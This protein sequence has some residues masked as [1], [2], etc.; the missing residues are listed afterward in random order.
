MKKN[1][2]QETKS[3][4]INNSHSIEPKVGTSNLRF[5]LTEITKEDWKSPENYSYFLCVLRVLCAFVRWIFSYLLYLR[6]S[7]KRIFYHRVSLRMALLATILLAGFFVGCNRNNTSERSTAALSGAKPGLGIKY[8]RNFS[9]NYLGN[10]VKLVTDS[11]RNKLLLVP[12]GVTAPSGYNDVVLIETPIERALFTSTTYVGFLGAL[13]TDSV[14]NS[15]AAVCTPEEEWPTP[16]ILARFRNG[17]TRYINHGL[18]A[19]GDIEEII[20][21]GAGFAFTAG[22]D[23]SDMRLRNLLDEV[24]IK[25]ATLLE[26]MEDGNLAYLEWIKFFAAFFNLDEEADRIFEGKL[27]RL[28]EL[29]EK[30]SLVSNIPTVAYG[31]IWSGMVFTQGGDSTLALQIEKAGGYYALKGLEGSGN[32]TITMEEFMKQCKDSDIII[33]GSSPQ[34]CPDKAFLLETEPLMAEFR[35]FKNDNIYVY[36]LGYYMNSAKVVE[37][38]EDM[39]SI[40]HPELFPGRELVMYKKL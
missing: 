3:L 21:T 10:G 17:T 14:Y 37:K 28:D 23:D 27:A 19:V 34:Y 5:A 16:Q 22:N 29:Y 2:V 38:F 36:D 35:A 26:W 20:K 30:A 39:V 8:A 9:I 40:F 32:V 18:A 15:V 1:K 12:K 24:N 25:Y 11:D 6:T 33:Y 7:Y 13:E 31:V 4:S